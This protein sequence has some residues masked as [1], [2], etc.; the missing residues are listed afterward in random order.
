MMDIS[1]TIVAKSDQLNADDLID[2]T[3][4]IR[5]KRV[6]VKADEQPVSISYEGDNGKPYKPG[7]SM[8]RVLAHA[9]G[10]DATVYAGRSLILYRDPT[11][12][13]GGLAV[14]GIRI[15]HM[16]D[17]TGNLT[18]ALTETRG[19]KKAFTVKPLKVEQSTSRASRQDTLDEAEAARLK[20]LGDEAAERGTDAANAFWGGRS[21]TERAALKPN[22]RGWL[23]RATA[24]DVERTSQ[25]S[26]MENADDR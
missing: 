10:K 22:V 20:D 4:T 8:R 24:V 12:R 26:T 18:V 19:S 5:I 13:F 25:S 14:G 23:A 2:R 16:S 7:K 9:W 17:I 11:I 15:S 3:I 21:E 1:P 6:N